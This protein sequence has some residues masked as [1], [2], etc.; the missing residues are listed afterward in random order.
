[1]VGFAPRRAAQQQGELT[2]GDGLLGEVIVDDQ[3]VLAGIAEELAHGDAGV[4]GDELERRRLGS[5]GGDDDGVIHGAVLFQL[6]NNLGDRGALLADGDVDA[7]H[8]PALL[9]DDG[10]DGDGG[11]A[12]LTVADDQLALTAP[13]RNHGVD[14]LEA[15]LHRLMHRLTLDDAGGLHFDLAEGGGGDGA[16]AV[17]RLADRV[18]HA[19]DQGLAHRDLDDLAGQ[20]DRVAFLDLG[21]LAENCRTDVVFLEVEDHAGDAARELQEL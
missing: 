11:L 4:G 1:R 17:D 14:R 16:Q 21:E 18:D 3:G 10:V 6:G 12:G 7:D 8:V 19:A 20:L 5:G 15:G 13:D 2:V 9:V